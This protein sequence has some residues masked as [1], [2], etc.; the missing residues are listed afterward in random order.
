MTAAGDSLV[1]DARRFPVGWRIWFQ[2]LLG[3]NLVA[4]LF[5]LEHPEA[6]A[7]LAG[8]VLSA[9]VIVP[10]HRCRGWVR[11][12]G[13]GHFPWLVIL[14]WIGLR[15]TVTEPSGAFGA[16]LVAVLVVDG[17]CLAIDA[18]DVVRYLAGERRPVVGSV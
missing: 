18:V 9:G 10:L 12:L 2:I 16:W 17:I 4:P 3:V 1:R 11:L 5:F 8:Y 7:V 14:P 6:W 15:M 13:T